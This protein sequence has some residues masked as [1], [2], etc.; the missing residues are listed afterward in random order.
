MKYGKLSSSAV[1]KLSFIVVQIEMIKIIIYPGRLCIS[2]SPP[3]KY[4][5]IPP[6]PVFHNMQQHCNNVLSLI[7][8]L[9]LWV[10]RQHFNLWKWCL[11]PQKKLP[12]CCIF[13][14]LHM[15]SQNCLL[16][17]QRENVWM[18]SF[19]NITRFRVS[20]LRVGEGGKLYL[21]L[22]CHFFIIII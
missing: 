7:T 22:C 19:W 13:S 15:T 21:H 1:S 9:L 5:C 16:H 6:S 20:V 17:I 2:T 11:I 18:I 14:M 3:S 12:F 10:D 8:P 4:L